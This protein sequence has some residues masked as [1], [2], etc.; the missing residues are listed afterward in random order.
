MPNTI[1]ADF[2]SF[3]T[4]FK[5]YINSIPF[6]KNIDKAYFFIF[7]HSGKQIQF[8]YKYKSNEE[9]TVNDIEGMRSESDIILKES[10]YELKQSYKKIDD[11]D[12][13][14]FIVNML[15]PVSN[16]REILG[17]LIIFT[18]QDSI[19]L[20]DI[21]VNYLMQ[22]IYHVET[23]ISNYHKIYYI[24][25]TFSEVMASKDK[26]MPYHMT[27]VANNCLELSIMLGLNPE[28]KMILYFAALL[29]D[30]GKL[31][32]SDDIVN[33]DGELTKE[34]EKLFELHSR[35]G[36]EMLRTLL[37]GMTLLSD[38]PIIVRH[39]H[40]RY[41]G[42]GYPDGLVGDKIPLLSRI[43]AVADAVDTIAKN[44]L[45][46][47]N[48]IIDKIIMDLKSKSGTYYDPSITKAMIKL[49]LS[50]KNMIQEDME[51][52]TTYIPHCSFGFSYM[53]KT[54]I[55]S[56]SGNLFLRENAGNFVIHDSDNKIYSIKAMLNTTISFFR[57]GN[58]EEYK[59][60]VSRYNNGEFYFENIKYLPTD[61]TFSMSWSS[62]AIVNNKERQKSYEVDIIKLGGDTV[63]FTLDRSSQLAT[64]ML[65][66]SIG[67]YQI[68]LS[69]EIE[70][71]KLD[72]TLNIK[73]VKYYKSSV[74]TFI[75]R[76]TTIQPS[77]K[78]KI[79]RILFRKQIE[80]RKWKAKMLND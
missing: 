12:G 6:F 27:N 31:F 10:S 38:I 71:I 62:K 66:N 36:Q 77:D 50:E 18:K 68:T 60:K 7:N 73:I 43:M 25:D 26:I 75:C 47:S 67:D 58:L 8:N 44:T 41:D 34:E 78:D 52:S 51:N 57:N 76:Y 29:H 74:Y 19:G 42:S 33:K 59:V 56:L 5:S 49:L 46:R 48:R 35:K 54:N 63:V 21:N 17:S 13:N 1:L 30:V 28:E 24:V 16:Y 55:R 11:Y 45:Y 32:V 4:Y 3:D 80:T 53:E 20:D 61:S 15:N 65:K 64:D 2:F 23:V 70:D 72:M 79:L 37:H 9:L 69:E 39:H 40:E 22:L 14:L